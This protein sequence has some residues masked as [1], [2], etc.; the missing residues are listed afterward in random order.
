MGKIRRLIG[1]L[2]IITGLGI[3]ASVVYNKV[4]TAQKQNELL[5]IFESEIIQGE[6]SDKDEPV[7]LESVNGHT[8]IA[9]M[10]IPRIKLKQPIV[11]GVTESVIKYFIGR[12]PDS[13][14]PGEV[15]NFAVAG[16]RVSNFTDAFINLYKV[17]PGDEVIVRTKDAKYT[18]KVED[19]FIVAPDQVEVLQDS[20]YEK[21]TMITC[22]I[23]S[24]KRVVVTGRLVE[25][26]EM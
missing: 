25:K 22:T 10:E 19:N 20:D 6:S 8:P 15:G 1:I 7:N 13:A 24:K 14:L 4:V 3:I 12:F 17:K 18:Y 5:E 23:G 26:E 2:L 11:N 9:I 16:H 21:I